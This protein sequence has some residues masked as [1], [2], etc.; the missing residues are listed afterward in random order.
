MKTE[1]L[2]IPCS[3]SSSLKVLHREKKQYALQTLLPML[4]CGYT[5]QRPHNI[6]GIEL[7]SCNRTQF[8][9]LHHHGIFLQT[10]VLKSCYKSSKICHQ[11]AVGASKPS[12]HECAWA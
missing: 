10:C 6:S 11:K 7:I 4:M 3:S 9:G 2:V 8:A 5:C 1:T 12:I